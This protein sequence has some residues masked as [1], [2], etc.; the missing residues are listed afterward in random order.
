M[1]KILP[2]LLRL[3]FGMN[4]RGLGLKEKNP[5]AFNLFEKVEPHYQH[6]VASGIME[7]FKI[8]I[9]NYSSS[10]TFTE[11]PTTS[12]SAFKRNRTYPSAISSPSVGTLILFQVRFQSSGFG[13][14]NF[15]SASRR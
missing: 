5:I 10:K 1:L 13:L 4:I 12:S 6:L 8:L 9:V 15:I 11:L 2:S 14:A 3:T 7:V